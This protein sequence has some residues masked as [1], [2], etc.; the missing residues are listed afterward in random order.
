MKKQNSTYELLSECCLNRDL[1]WHKNHFEVMIWSGKVIHRWS[2]N[3]FYFIN[4]KGCRKYG[5]ADI[6]ILCS[7]W[8]CAYAIFM[9]VC[10][11]VCPWIQFC[12]ELPLLNHSPLCDQNLLYDNA[13]VG[14]WSRSVIALVFSEIIFSDHTDL[15]QNFSTIFVFSERWA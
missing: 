8:S 15:S 4:C 10:A 13:L 9:S 7:M 5:Y 2:E 11:S 14:V 1:S 12:A 3:K 6:M